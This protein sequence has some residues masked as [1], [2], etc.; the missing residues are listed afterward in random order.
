MSTGEEPPVVR[1][2]GDVKRFGQ[3]EE[4]KLEEEYLKEMIYEMMDEDQIEYFEKKGRL[5][6]FLCS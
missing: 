3:D 2:D 1:I 5:R 6:L 4:S